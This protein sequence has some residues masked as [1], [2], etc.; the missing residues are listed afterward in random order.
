MRRFFYALV[1]ASLVAET[2][3]MFAKGHWQTPLR[4]LATLLFEWK[5]LFLPVI[6]LILVALWLLSTSEGPKLRSRGLARAIGVAIVAMIAW[7]L[8]GMLRG[9]L[10][11][12]IQFQLHAWFI[13]FV[14][15]LL[16]HKILYTPAHFYALAKVIVLAALVRASMCI[17]FYVLVVREGVLKTIPEFITTHDDTVLF[18]SALVAVVVNALEQPTGKNF[19]I[20]ALVSAVMLLAIQF[21]N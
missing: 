4:L 3:E 8:W 18:V 20:A 21:N 16:M 19:R 2:S 15:A 5:P 14:C 10:F 7:S 17:A 9:G 11:Y 6:D 13:A 1:F 12:Q